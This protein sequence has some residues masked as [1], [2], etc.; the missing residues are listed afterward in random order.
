[1]LHISYRTTDYDKQHRRLKLHRGFAVHEAVA[2]PM[3]DG[4]VCL[5]KNDMNTYPHRF[6]YYE[7]TLFDLGAVH[8]LL[9]IS[10]R[11]TI[12]IN[13]FLVNE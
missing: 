5:E 13:Y 10:G 2:T 9:L 3:A 12:D 8:L 6:I 7:P 11:L 4:A 1:M